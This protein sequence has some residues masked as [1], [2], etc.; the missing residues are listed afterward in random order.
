MA[1]ETQARRDPLIV[2]VHVPKA[3]GST[4]NTHLRQF[5]ANGIDH[6]QR[7]LRDKARLARIVQ[8]VDWISGHIGF[9]PFRTLLSRLTD[10]ELRFFTCVR[11]PAEQVASHYNWLIRIRRK[12]LLGYLRHPADI[13]RVS[14]RLRGSDNGDPAAVAANLAAHPALFFNVQTR[15]V[16]GGKPAQRPRTMAQGLARYEAITTTEGIGALVAKMTGDAAPAA[17]REN[18]S[19]YQVRADL[20]R[21]GPVRALLDRENARDTA[22]FDAVR[23]AEAGRAEAIRAER[24]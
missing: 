19:P 14:R 3:G 10:R 4:V 24:D 5:S 1:P 16:F 13:R 23:V 11:D 7:Y 9:P 20:F 12:S 8:N 18:A 15:Y 6:C 22:L 21:D 2:F 17:L